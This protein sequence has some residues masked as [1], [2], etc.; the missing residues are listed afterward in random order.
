[1]LY[2]DNNIISLP[3]YTDLGGYSFFY[4][5]YTLNSILFFLVSAMLTLA[6][7]AFT[8]RHLLPSKLNSLVSFENT[9]VIGLIT[10]STLLL[11]FS[12]VYKTPDSLYLEGLNAYTAN[13]VFL[14]LFLLTVPA[15]FTL[16]V[17]QEQITTL[18]VGLNFLFLLLVVFFLI[19][20]ESLIGMVMGYE[21][22]FLPSF[23][24]MRKTIY[25]ASAQSAYSVF[26]VWSVLGSLI[27]VG[28][29]VFLVVKTGE[30]SFSSLQLVLQ[31]WDDAELFALS[32]LF[33]IGFGVKIPI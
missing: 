16:L 4:N 15:T 3:S 19:N 29:A 21:L 32:L 18:F 23:L 30:H 25:S 26:T 31:G 12:V 22:V 6:C 9:A 7:F 24:I 5:P 2:K 14:V 8:L 17:R 20:T 13:K 28:A 1:M 10:I 27:V 33:F 11:V